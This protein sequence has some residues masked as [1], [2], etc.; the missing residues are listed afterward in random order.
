MMFPGSS[1]TMTKIA[2]E[3]VNRV[4]KSERARWTRNLAIRCR[5]AAGGGSGPGPA[6]PPAVSCDQ[7]SM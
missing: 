1:R 4:A 6:P 3:T 5:D 2:T 7:A